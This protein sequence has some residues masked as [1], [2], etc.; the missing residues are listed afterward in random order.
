MTRSEPRSPAEHYAEADR[1]L[2][3]SATHRNQ[4]A[5]CVRAKVARAAVH[6]HLA[7]CPDWYGDFFD[8]GPPT[9]MVET[10][11]GTAARVMALVGDQVF[12]LSKFTQSRDQPLESEWTPAPDFS[13]YP[14][15]ITDPKGPSPRAC[16]R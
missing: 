7:Q 9:R 4:N 2:V 10:P 3:E 8:E 16:N 13:K 11:N 6:A 1:L 15:A 12:H 14:P 5:P